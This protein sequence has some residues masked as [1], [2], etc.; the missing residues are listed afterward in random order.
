MRSLEDLR[1]T[2]A[3]AAPKMQGRGR[4]AHGAAGDGW[5]DEDSGRARERLDRDMEALYHLPT[6]KFGHLTPE[7]VAEILSPLSSRCEHHQRDPGGRQRPEGVAMAGE[8]AAL[9]R[10]RTSIAY[11]SRYSVPEGVE[12]QWS[13]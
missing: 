2:A 7:E 11:M 4:A 9:L 8:V 3:I 6:E 10:N 1:L 12:S 13:Q 5:L